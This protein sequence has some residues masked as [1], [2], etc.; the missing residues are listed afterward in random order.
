M[1]THDFE[2]VVQSMSLFYMN[3]VLD[4]ISVMDVAENLDHPSIFLF[5]L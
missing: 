3:S 5:S 2:L 1:K 4:Y